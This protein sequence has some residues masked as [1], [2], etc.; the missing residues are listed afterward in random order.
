MPELDSSKLTDPSSSDE[1]LDAFLS[2][3]ETSGT[4]PYD[5]QEEAIL[6]LF[7][8]SN[9]ILNTPTGSG[10]S[11][12]ALALQYRAI[13][14]KRR[15]Y[16]TVPIKALANEKF[17]SLC[18]TFGPENIGMI[19]GD[20]T[21]NPSAP[22]I[23]CTAEILA[24]LALREGAAAPVDDVIMDEFHY[25]SDHERG[26]AWQVPLL[27][28][29]NA[30]FLL[31]SATIGDTEFF[32]ETI[33][34]LTGAPTALVKSEDRPVPLE[35]EYSTLALEEKIEEL[36]TANRAP[37]YLV[38]FT[39]LSCAQ[40][41][42]DL[43]SRNFCSKEE[44]QAIA[45]LLVDADF[46]SPY[47]KEMKKFLRHGLG[48]HHAGLLPKYRTLVEKL[49]QKGLLKVICGTDTLGVG[50]NVPI[51]TVVFTRLFKYGGQS[52]KTLAVRD[53]K[54]IAGRAGRRGFDDIGYVVAQAPE[55]VIANIKADAKAAAK[56]GKS[57]AVKKKPPEKGFVNWDENTFRK[58]IDSPSEKLSSSFV[59]SH[60]M[61]LNVLSRRNEDGCEE[62]RRIIRDSHETPSKKADLRKRAFGLFRGLVEGNILRIIP[63][64]KRE[65]PAKVALNIELQDDFSLNQALAAYLVEAIPQLNPEEPAY[66][67]NVISLAEAIVE[68]PTQV[69]RKQLDKAKDKLVAEMK[70][71]GIEYDARMDALEQVEHPKPGKEFIYATY[72]EFV[73]KNPWAKEAAVRPKSIAREMFEDYSSFE[74][75]IKTYGLEKSE[76]VLL[77][78]LSEV[79]KIL[80]QTVPDSHK[81]PELEEAE[82]F[83]GTMIRSTDSSLLDEWE[84]LRNPDATD[85]SEAPV[86]ANP[87]PYTRNKKALTRD[88]RSAIL[89]FVKLLSQGRYED[90]LSLAGSDLST[91]ELRCIMEEFH[92]SHGLILL[93]PEARNAK[94]TRIREVPEKGIWAISQTLVDQEEFND[95]TAEFELDLKATEDKRSPDLRFLGITNNR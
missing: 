41:A 3:L 21:V 90:A 59:M 65:T 14:M 85:Q 27:T 52:T 62:L 6:E 16:Y 26:V 10:K 87:I 71:D 60:S 32:Q 7:A 1:I 86:S 84:K 53:F 19:T 45:D 2:Y 18:K 55:H 37:I 67:L 12:V 64:D 42:Q 61:L 47:G 68:D 93:D 4:I 76:A 69:I 15:C 95:H 91:S 66:P 56:G 77:R 48:I 31:M 39:Q 23:C 38:H 22:V 89:G 79:Y 63:K 33:T 36:V 34:T 9:V 51:R 5:H 70:A 29:P 75:Y 83:F 57:K 94:H 88:V 20:A 17:L 28:L 54:Q 92:Q 30:R 80:A 82:T 58:L 81:T 11:L 43:M 44:K 8:G 72:N 74:D 73:L 13:C 35:F 49:A 25:Y 40:T 46:R 78:H 24:N 50:V